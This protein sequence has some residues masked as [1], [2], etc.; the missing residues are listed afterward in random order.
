[1][2]VLTIDLGPGVTAL[3]T[4]R[5]GG[6]STGA[7]AS[8]DL[9]YHVGDDPAAVRANRT[10][11]EDRLGARVAYANQVHGA[12]VAVVDGTPPPGDEPVGDADAL[13][14]RTGV[15]LGVL[16]ADCLPVLLADR[17][18]GVVGAVHAGRRGLVKGV[19]PSAVEVMARQGA[20]PSDVRAYLGPAICGRCYEVGAQVQDEVTRVVPEAGAT[21][22]WGTSAVDLVAGVEAQLAAAGVGEVQRAEICTREDPRF[23]SYRRD[24][25]TGRFAGVIVLHHHDTP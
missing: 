17:R 15:G 23:Y 2:D 19:V 8:L 5:A 12:E 24:G 18:H 20:V 6:V 11:V 10:T 22:S 7:Y 3:V 13:V 21:S 14:T 1:M 4:T 16:V 25:T 9:A